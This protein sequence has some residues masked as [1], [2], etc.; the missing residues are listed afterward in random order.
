MFMEYDRSQIMIK[1]EAFEFGSDEQSVL[2]LKL[3]LKLKILF[4][5]FTTFELISLCQD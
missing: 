1:F 5:P 3:I 4:S 2:E